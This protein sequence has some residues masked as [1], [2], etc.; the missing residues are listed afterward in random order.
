M[1]QICQGQSFQTHSQNVT[2]PSVAPDSRAVPLL[3]CLH[4]QESTCLAE[5]KSLAKNWRKAAGSSYHT[6]SICFH[7]GFKLRGTDWWRV[8]QERQ[9][10]N[11]WSMS[12][13]PTIAY[14]CYLLQLCVVK[15]KVQNR[16]HLNTRFCLS[17]IF[18]CMA[19][20]NND[21]QIWFQKILLKWKS[22]RTDGILTLCP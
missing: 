7:L 2:Q 20:G 16:C 14:L 6:S 12:Q 18:P 17:K 8:F 15:L 21:L 22:H 10:L 1:L 19:N 11:W 3:F 5:G 13:V 9:P 4:K